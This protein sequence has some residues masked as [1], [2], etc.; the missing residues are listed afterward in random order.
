MRNILLLAAIALISINSQSFGQ[1]SSDDHAI[2]VLNN[3]QQEMV[4]CVA[5]YKTVSICIA[6][7]GDHKTSQTYTKMAEN[8][9]VY[10]AVIAI[11]IGLSQ[12]AVISRNKIASEHMYNLMKGQC[13]NISSAISRYGTS[14]PE[15]SKDPLKSI[16]PYLQ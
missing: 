4:I 10:S 16:A 2:S 7:R 13:I 14:C 9:L 5:Y 1:I 12:D 3:A 6:N 11:E 8:L 15:L